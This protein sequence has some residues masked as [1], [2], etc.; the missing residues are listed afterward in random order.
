MS[1]TRSFSIQK[2]LDLSLHHAG[3]LP[4]LLAVLLAG[5]FASQSAM[6][7]TPVYQSDELDPTWVETPPAVIMASL[8]ER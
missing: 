8:K 2:W 5:L 3:I 4:A 7:Q 6:A 1:F